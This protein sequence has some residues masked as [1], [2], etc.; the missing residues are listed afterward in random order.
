MKKK[1]LAV[2]SCAILIFVAGMSWHFLTAN[3]AFN[4]N[5]LMDDSVFDNANSM[6][7]PGIDAWLNANFPTSCISTNSGFSSPALLGYSPSTGFSY[8]GNV[9]AGT[10][11]YQAA[12]A[13][14]LNPE[15]ILATLQK[16][17]SVVSGTASYHCQYINTAMG[18]DC[19][20][21]GNCPQN[22]A[23]ESGFSKQVIHAAWL[24]K[25]HEQR[26]KGNTGWNVQLTNFPYPGDRWDNSDDPQSCYS[27]RMTQGVFATCPGGP[28]SYY[29]G[30]T[31]IDGTAVHVDTGATAALYDY[32][33]HFSG[34]QHFDSLFTGYF[35]GI[36]GSA[37]N[38][39]QY[40]QS[41][42]PQLDPGQQANVSLEFQNMGSIAW[43]DDQ[44]IGGA[45]GGSFPVHLATAHALNRASS[46]SSGWPT[47]SRPALNFAAVYESDGVTLASN[48][49]VAQPGQ[50]VKFSF[51]LTAPSN[52][53][54][55]VYREFFQPVAEGVGNGGFNDVSTF[56]DVTVNPKPAMAWYDQSGYPTIYPSDKSSVY[57]RFKNTGNTTFYDSAGLGQAPAGTNPLHLATRSPLNRN[58]DFSGDW[59]TPS[60]PALNFAAVYESDGVTL[61]SNQH[62]A[63]P[64]QIVK[65]QFNLTPPPGYAANT[66][67][68]D[69]QPVLEGTGDGGLG[70]VGGS[71]N[72]TVPSA[73]VISYTSLPNPAQ[74]VS[75]TPG[76]IGFTIENAGNANLA[77]NTKLVTSN[78]SPF[79]ASTWTDNNTISANIGGSAL[80]PLQTRNI[81]FNVLTP[82]SGSQPNTPVNIS[83][84][85]QSNNVIPLSPAAIPVNI[86]PASYQ[87]A[88]VSQSGYPAFTYGQTQ[89]TYFMYKNTGNQYWYD[90][91]SLP[92]ATTK[93]PYAIHLATDDPLNR[94]S[95][96]D[97]AW[98]T[99]SRPALNFAAVY[100]SDGVTLASNQH[101]AQPGQ[102]VKF[103][104]NITPSVNLAP[105]VYREFFQPV[106]EGTANGGFPRAW[107]FIDI[108]LVNPTY[109]A[110]QTSQSA[111]PTLNRGQ[112]T[113]VFFNYRN[114]GAAPWYDSTSI[115][116]APTNAY[117]VHLA[118]SHGLNRL[119]S[120][121]S[122]WP[123]P[124]RPALNFAAVYESDGV[125]LAS[126]QHVAQPGQIVKF[127]F[128]LTAPSGLTPGV[129]REFFNPLAEGTSDGAF[130]DT[131]TFFD[132]TVQ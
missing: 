92:T 87:S 34:N 93:A 54:A 121:S 59:P 60:R 63:Q 45:P 120:F 131:W 52:V 98:P 14:G 25:F 49:H 130:N 31:T 6:D 118:T 129:Y 107:T 83:F 75:N 5:D 125:T 77:A 23:T 72:V 91:T 9:S 42:Y 79:K 7:G 128:T 2:F 67:S 78:G 116:Q 66:Y 96:F 126:N 110:N 20:D 71:L 109:V 103:Q 29:D 99:P 18:Y 95:G 43:Y 44:S 51:T 68:E 53:A 97:Q 132:V 12:H 65:F 64:G 10:V 85:D 40:T 56:F 48:Q 106:A 74:L 76:T 55:G 84:Q 30:M 89:T 123:T 104:F 3:A 57:L 111:Y 35:G 88:N 119:S 21:S 39:A 108:T 69:F 62:V 127:S 101:V 86:A 19:P 13:Y 122:G 1:L 17:S 36:Y 32:T 73:A 112:Q 16:E 11:I 102:I 4:A 113:T 80:A 117:P 82:D 38:A 37:Y 8:G 115:G 114:N 26:S 47:P 61:A 22:P 94:S 28:V 27:G 15:V 90:S 105:G 33:P 124:S 100:E 24:F 41:A 50:I 81:S 58:S 46:F 70:T